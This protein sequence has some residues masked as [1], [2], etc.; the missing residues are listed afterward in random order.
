M[1]W[2][3]YIV[4]PE[5]GLNGWWG[6]TIIQVCGGPAFVLS[7]YKIAGFFGHLKF[8]S[9]HVDISLSSCYYLLRL[10]QLR[11]EVGSKNR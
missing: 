7:Y 9:D 11:F 3:G 2:D 6:H 4:R 10:Q 1:D 8:G 5:C